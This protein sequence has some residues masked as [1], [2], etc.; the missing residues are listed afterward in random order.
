MTR[1]SWGVRR[2][3]GERLVGYSEEREM[4][5]YLKLRRKLFKYSNLKNGRGIICV[6]VL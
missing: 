2:S 3:F 6:E 4:S 1:Q 5:F